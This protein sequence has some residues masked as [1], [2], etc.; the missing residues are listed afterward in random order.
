MSFFVS[1]RRGDRVGDGGISESFHIFGDLGDLGERETFDGK[2]SILSLV[3]TLRESS[4][5]LRC[6]CGK[7][8]DVVIVPPCF[9]SDPLFAGMAL[10]GVV[11]GVSVGTELAGVG[12]VSKWP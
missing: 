10:L 6:I 1:R 8:S 12:P 2:S 11:L 3:L 4:D 9:C 5:L 7:L